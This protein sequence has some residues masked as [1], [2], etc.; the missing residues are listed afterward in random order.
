[1]KGGGLNPWNFLSNAA[2]LVFSAF[3]GSWEKILPSARM[4]AESPLF[5]VLLLGFVVSGLLALHVDHT[6]SDAFS[7]FWHDPRQNL[8][9]ALKSTRQQAQGT[10]AGAPGNPPKPQPPVA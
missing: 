2:M 9:T 1:M 4:L 10:S 8:R 3:T 5:L 7:R 6:R